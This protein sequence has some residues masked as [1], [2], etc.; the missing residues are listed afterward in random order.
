MQLTIWAEEATFLLCPLKRFHFGDYFLF[1]VSCEANAKLTT[2]LCPPV[3]VQMSP[4]PG[5]NHTDS[6][7]DMFPEQA[8]QPLTPA[9]C[10]L[11]SLWEGSSLFFVVRIK[12][13]YNNLYSI[14]FKISIILE[15]GVVGE[16]GK[17]ISDK[18]EFVS[19]HTAALDNMVA[20]CSYFNLIR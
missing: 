16:M 5:T 19:C 8:L 10:H 1:L 7:S 13:K 6:R 9:P 20:I 4:M 3:S 2:F 18:T 15:A 12:F 11:D 14:C 17:M